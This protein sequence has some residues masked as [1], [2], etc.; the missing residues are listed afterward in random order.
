MQHR[1]T[2]A[3]LGLT[4]TLLMLSFGCRANLPDGT[5]ACDSDEDC[6]GGLTCHQSR[7]YL[8]APDAGPDFDGGALD[9]S[10]D[11]D[12]GERTD[13]PI[14]GSVPDGGLGDGGT[15]DGGHDGGTIEIDAG[16]GCEVLGCPS[17]E[18]CDTASGACVSGCDEEMDCDTNETCTDD[19]CACEAE[20]HRCAA[21]CVSDHEVSSCGD[22]C[23]TCPDV[24]DGIAT[25]D[26]TNCGIACDTGYHECSG[27]CAANTSIASCG[28]SCTSCPAVSHGAPTCNGTSCGFVCDAGYHPCGSACVLDTALATCGSACAPCA[29]VANA[30]ETCNGV[31]CGFSCDPTFHGCGSGCASNTSVA[32]CGTRCTTCPDVANAAETCDGTACGFTCNPGYHRCGAGCAPDASVL[33]CGGSCTACA[34]VPRAS[35]TCDGVSCGFVCDSG[36]RECAGGCSV[37]PSA[38]VA[39]TTCASAACIAASC[40]SGFDLRSEYCC[41][42]ESASVS[43]FGPVEQMGELGPSSATWRRPNPGGTPPTYCYGPLR[44]ETTYRNAHVFCNPGPAMVVDIYLEGSA[45]GFTLPDPVAFVYPGAG[46]PADPLTCIGS[47]DDG[48]GTSSWVEGMVVPAGAVFTVVAGAFGPSSGT[49]TYRIRIVPR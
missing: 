25:C 6:P 19:F 42:M 26:G 33:T 2:L 45:Q 13:A 3:R 14:D 32:T 38:G 15:G 8:A 7:C 21:G 17:G 35:E 24:I 9:T 27:A 37:C 20:H 46:F 44:G 4:A 43:A 48:L 28:A 29:D 10:P 16:P 41:P 49:G 11:D 47:A 22:R 31:S 39:S 23:V 30:T 40:S 5:F 12:A 18:R 36:T 1:N 34:D